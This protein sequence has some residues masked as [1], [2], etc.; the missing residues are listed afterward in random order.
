MKANELVAKCIP[1]H[2]AIGDDESH[3]HCDACADVI[4]ARCLAAVNEALEWA[5]ERA[6]LDVAKTSNP[7]GLAIADMI[8]AGKG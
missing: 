3:Y 5:A 8:R 7:A 2:N 1:E 4:H 6:E